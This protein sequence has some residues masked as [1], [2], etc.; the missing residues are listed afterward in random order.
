MDPSPLTTLFTL[1][2]IERL[3]NLSQQYI[4]RL[5]AATVD[6]APNNLQSRG[7][8]PNIAALQKDHFLPTRDVM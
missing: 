6:S 8:I 4:L 1:C 2:G 5:P 7:K 3:F